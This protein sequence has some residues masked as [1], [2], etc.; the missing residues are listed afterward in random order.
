MNDLWPQYL[1]TWHDAALLLGLPLAAVG[2]VAAVVTGSV[3]GAALLLVVLTS[4]L[5]HLGGAMWA[6][7]IQLN[8]VSG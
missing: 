6:A 7:G 1:S 8:A 3:W 4:L 5:I 2:G